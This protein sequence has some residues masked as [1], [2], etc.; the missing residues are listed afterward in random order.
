VERARALRWR[1]ES[2]ARL[3]DELRPAAGGGVPPR[4]PASGEPAAADPLLRL[5]EPERVAVAGAYW[6]GLTQSEVAER[7]DEPLDTVRCHLRGGLE[8]LGA[9]GPA[10]GGASAHEP[11]DTDAPVYALG[12]LDGEALIRFEAHLA[13][14]CRR[15][16]QALARWERVLATLAAAAPAAAPPH[17]VRAELLARA[18]AE[19]PRLAQQRALRRRWLWGTFGAATALLAGALLGGWFVAIRYEARLGSLARELSAVRRLLAERDPGAAEPALG[20]LLR[21]PATRVFALRGTTGEVAGRVVW[22]D[23][24]GGW[25]FAGPLLPAPEGRVY[26]LWALRA[27]RPYPGGPLALSP[28]GHVAQRVP[29][30]PG[31][32]EAFVVSVEPSA[33]GPEPAGPVSLSSGPEPGAGRGI[34]TP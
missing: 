31:P 24:V 15:C 17:E 23:G 14:G 1:R 2:L 4:V 28:E 33:P 5:P 6:E 19:P 25:L 30:V 22:R 18:A 7:L 12:A 34:L 10:A 16:R 32:V 27:G 29:V 9:L 11:F 20:A 8:R 26:A 21:H 3:G 13:E